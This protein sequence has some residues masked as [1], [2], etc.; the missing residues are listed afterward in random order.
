MREKRLLFFVLLICIGGLLRFGFYKGSL[1]LDEFTAI[2]LGEKNPPNL[3]ASLDRTQHAPPLDYMCHHVASYLPEFEHQFH[4]FSLFLGL[5]S[6]V[7]MYRLGEFLFD[8]RIGIAAAVLL[9]IHWFPVHYSLEA[10]MYSSFLF[11]TMLSTLFLF[12]IIRS[13][14]ISDWL[15]YAAST[16]VYLY[17]HYFGIFILAVQLGLLGLEFIIRLCGRSRR[18][19]IGNYS[20]LLVVTLALIFIGYLPWLFHLIHKITTTAAISAPSKFGNHLTSETLLVVLRALTLDLQMPYL[21]IIPLLF[22]IVGL[23]SC[24][25][26]RFYKL[27]IF[28]TIYVPF[29]ILFLLY[30]LTRSKTFFAVRYFIFMLPFVILMILR[31]FDITAHLVVRAAG[32]VLSGLSSRGYKMSVYAFSTLVLLLGTGYALDLPKSSR[33]TA[34]S[35][36]RIASIVKKGFSEGDCILIGPGE[37]H[38]FKYTFYYRR[39]PYRKVLGFLPQS[40]EELRFMVSR[41][42]TVWVIFPK[43]GMASEEVAPLLKQWFELVKEF[44]EAWIFKSRDLDRFRFMVSSL[45]IEPEWKHISY[46]LVDNAC[47]LLP[48]DAKECVFPLEFEEPGEYAFLLETTGQP[49]PETLSLSV[50]GKD[51]SLAPIT[52]AVDAAKQ[53]VTGHLDVESSGTVRLRLVQQ[54]PSVRIAALNIT[55]THDSVL[56][57]IPILIRK[58]LVPSNH[59]PLVRAKIQKPSGETRNARFPFSWNSDETVLLEMSQGEMMVSKP[60][61]VIELSSGREASLASMS[62]NDLVVSVI[63]DEK[64]RVIKSRIQEGTLRFQVGLTYPDYERTVKIRTREGAALKEIHFSACSFEGIKPPVNVK[65]GVE[66]LGYGIEPE[67]APLGEPRKITLYWRCDEPFNRDVNRLFSFNDG[68]TPLYRSLELLLSGMSKTSSWQKGQ[69]V[70][71][72]IRFTPRKIAQDKRLFNVA[73]NFFYRSELGGFVKDM[74]TYDSFRLF[75]YVQVGPIEAH[76][77]TASAYRLDSMPE[78]MIPVEDIIGDAIRWVGCDVQQNDRALLMT[79]YFQCLDVTDKNLFFQFYFIRGNEIVLFAQGTP[80]ESCFGNTSNWQK[81][82]ILKDQ[83]AVPLRP[84]LQPGTYELRS[85]VIDLNTRTVLINKKLVGTVDLGQR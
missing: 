63:H 18:K 46:A 21:F 27:A 33:L 39:D 37:E 77:E 52:L 26:K 58:K 7:L 67:I 3:F 53:R 9:T 82:D 54:T 73:V 8:R 71:E 5:A 38:I 85:T 14:H 30:F 75:D 22:F 76:S 35:W 45:L 29:F 44:P 12:R 4:L 11:W 25:K 23:I 70:K 61:V 51:G 66:F 47:T 55:Q 24:M 57:K 72:V 34:Q 59:Y 60:E 68:Y 43:N 31:G 84:G 74:T 50:A 48:N 78:P 62:S 36:S 16:L 41:F 19:T 49:T 56:K 40:K 13:S 64:E 69:I 28:T 17:L 42:N 20:L 81:G 32:R 65:G 83:I 10:R 15:A 79:N 6:I 1:W 2:D 80:F